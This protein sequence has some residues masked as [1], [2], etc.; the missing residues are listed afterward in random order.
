MA[1]QKRAGIEMDFVFGKSNRQRPR[2]DAEVPMRMLIIGDFA[3]HASQGEVRTGAR[4]GR[5]G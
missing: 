4:R 3:G 5:A 2:P 1:D